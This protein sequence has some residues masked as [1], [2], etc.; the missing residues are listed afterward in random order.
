MRKLDIGI[1][2]CGTAGP[3]TALF[4]A[5]QGHSVTVYE[6]VPDPSPIGAGIILQPTGQAVLR[7]LGLYDAIVPRGERLKGLRVQRHGKGKLI[8]LAYS[9]VS[10]E[11]F[12]VGLHR[13]ALFA[14]LFDAVRTEPNVRLLL[15]VHCEGLVKEGHRFAVVTERGERVG[16]HDL[17]VAADGARSRFRDDTG[18]TRSQS[19]YPFGALWFVAKDEKDAFKDDLFQVVNGTTRMLG[20]LPTGVGPR[21]G[22]PDGARLVSLYW[23]IAADAVD[24]WRANGFDAWRDEIVDMVPEAADVVAQI[25]SPD[26][27][28]FSRYYDVVMRPWH[29]RAVVHLGD[30]AHAMSPQLGQGANLA[31]WDAMVLSDCIQAEPNDIVRAL[32]AYS[33]TRRSHLGYYEL[34][35]RAL[36]PFFQSHLGVL[37]LLR[38]LSMPL[39][40]KI[41]PFRRAMVLGMTGT[42]AGSP[43]RELTLP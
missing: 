32:T 4:L 17:I 39:L 26:A 41:G 16:V 43:F 12:G 2:G 24:E 9:D 42:A 29:T 3:A 21:N 33:R 6:R 27:V 35:T 5:R 20:L 8:E 1:I 13:G 30:S 34:V 38:D 31:L 14:G 36:T 10:S 37:G 11:Y 28:L 25:Q 22:S 23:S 18:I 19:P 40:G 15:G 7:R